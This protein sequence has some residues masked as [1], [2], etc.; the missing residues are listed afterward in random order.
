M[1]D[2]ICC[3]FAKDLEESGVWLLG[4]LSRMTKLSLLPLTTLSSPRNTWYLDNDFVMFFSVSVVFH[5]S[6]DLFLLVPRIISL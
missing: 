2:C 5:N 3:L 1:I 6:K 4:L